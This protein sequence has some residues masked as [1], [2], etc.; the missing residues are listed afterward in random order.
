MENKRP[1]PKSNRGEMKLRMTQPSS[2][3]IEP[4]VPTIGVNNKVIGR[5]RTQ[6]GALPKDWEQRMI[7]E[8]NKGGGPTAFMVV[9]EIG[10]H[11]LETLLTDSEI[12]RN[13]YSKCMLLSKYWW[14]NTGRD[15]ASGAKEKGNASAWSLNMTNRFNWRSGRQEI[16]GDRDAP[17][18]VEHGKRDLTKE[19]LLAELKSRNLPTNIFEK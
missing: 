15:L 8:A 19:E 11:A 4:V 10:T 14:E 3:P 9:L 12:F 16:V 1:K 13:T 17:L 18:G 7:D 6:L 5:P 2:A